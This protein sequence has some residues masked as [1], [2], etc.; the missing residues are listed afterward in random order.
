MVGQEQ[1]KLTLILDPDNEQ[2]YLLYGKCGPTQ[3]NQPTT[4][5]CGPVSTMGLFFWS[6]YT[7]KWFSMNL[8]V[9]GIEVRYNVRDTNYIENLKKDLSKELREHITS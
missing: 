1:V 3:P 2:L 8:D 7:V 6:R 4:T 9:N 5:V